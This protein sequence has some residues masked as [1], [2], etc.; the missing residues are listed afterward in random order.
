MRIRIVNDGRVLDG[1]AEQIVQQLQY[2]AF[3]KEETSMSEYVDWLAAQVARQE[4]VELK[5]EGA[6]GRDKAAALV[7][8]MVEAELAVKL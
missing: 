6:T 7:K 1:T 4:G 8:A 5:V 2:I 3:G